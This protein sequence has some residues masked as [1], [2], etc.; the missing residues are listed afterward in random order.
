[1]LHGAERFCKRGDSKYDKLFDD[2][3]S[4]YNFFNWSMKIVKKL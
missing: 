1:M 2:L 4:L 3:E